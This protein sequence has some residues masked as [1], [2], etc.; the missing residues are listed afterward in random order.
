MLPRC[1]RG[2]TSCPERERG[3]VRPACSAFGFRAR[4]PPSAGVARAEARRDWAETCGVVVTRGVDDVKRGSDVRCGSDVQRGGRVS[5]DDTCVVNAASLR[6]EA[7]EVRP[8]VVE[9]AEGDAQHIGNVNAHVRADG[10]ARGRAHV[11]VGANTKARASDGV[12]ACAHVGADDDEFARAHLGAVDVSIGRA[13]VGVASVRA[14]QASTTHPVGAAPRSTST[15]RSRSAPCASHR[16][17]ALSSRS[18]HLNEIS[19]RSNTRSPAGFD[20]LAGFTPYAIAA[21]IQRRI[22]SPATIMGTPSVQ[23]GIT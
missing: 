6:G 14:A 5:R 21:G 7:I 20:G 2:K 11:G 15:R 10:E 8:Q 18:R 3:V 1:S 16:T 12:D 13:H 17:E 22:L 19:S 4:V 23:P 9:M